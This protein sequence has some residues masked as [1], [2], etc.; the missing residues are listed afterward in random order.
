M[1]EKI[2]INDDGTFALPG[3][4]LDATKVRMQVSRIRW[5]DEA[6]SA[7][8]PIAIFPPQARP[9]P[10]W[11]PALAPIRRVEF[12]VTE[13]DG[14]PCRGGTALIAPG[15]H[16]LDLGEPELHIALDH[17]GRAAVLLPTDGMKWAI[18]VV[19]VSGHASAIVGPDDTRIQLQL[20]PFVELP[21]RVTDENAQ[22]VAN[23]RIDIASWGQME[24]STDIEPKLRE[25]IA[26]LAQE[27]YVET[28]TDAQGMFVLRFLPVP[29]RTVRARAIANNK[30]S[31]SFMVM[32][33]EGPLALVVRSDG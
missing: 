29:R 28:T 11:D 19:Q 15:D 14:T 13:A 21:G 3:L 7:L 30:K 6:G 18:A 12:E 31:G 4:P 23:A 17:A 9:Q 10:G 33:Q 16:S 20:E 25:E 8:V 22:P 26:T 24:P 5:T 32:P 1:A 27:R 2:S